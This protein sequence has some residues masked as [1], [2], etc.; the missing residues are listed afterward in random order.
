MLPSA[1]QFAEYVTLLGI[2]NSDAVVL[3][4]SCDTQVWYVSLLQFQKT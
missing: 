1:E 3:Y 2:G 4:D